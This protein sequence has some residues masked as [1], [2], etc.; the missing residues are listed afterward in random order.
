MWSFHEQQLIGSGPTFYLKMSLTKILQEVSRRAPRFSHF[1]PFSHK[2][3]DFRSLKSHRALL[4][5]LIL[6]LTLFASDRNLIQT[7]LSKRTTK[8]GSWLFLCFCVCMYVCICLYL[9]SVCLNVGF[10][11]SRI[12]V[13]SPTSNSFLSAVRQACL[14]GSSS[15]GTICIKIPGKDFDGFCLDHMPTP[16]QSL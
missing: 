3:S 9:S 12:A 4:F 15:F 10:L 6:I 8:C 11:P 2:L 5:P 14:R 16:D 7:S 1:F 13:F